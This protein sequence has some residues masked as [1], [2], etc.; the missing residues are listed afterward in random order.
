MDRIRTR[1]KAFTLVELLVVIAIVAILISVLL[2]AIASARDSARTSVASN[3]VRQIVA[4]FTIYANEHEGQYPPI[5]NNIRDPRTDKINMHW[6]DE[7]RIGAYLPQFDDSN[8]DPDNPKNNT[9]GG[10]VFTSPMHPAAGRS[11]TMNF[12]GASAG[13]WWPAGNGRFDFFKPGQDYQH[14]PEQVG[15]GKAFDYNTDFASNVFLIT[16][17][18]GLWPSQSA[19][20]YTGEKRWFTGAQV[21]ADGLPGQRF[22]GGEEPINAAVETLAWKN[23]GA[24]EMAGIEGNELPTYVP[25]YRYPKRDRDP[26]TRTGA[27]MFGMVDGHVEMLRA[28]EVVDDTTGRSSYRVLWSTEDR[29]IENDAY[30]TQP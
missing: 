2:P 22:G 4:A 29:K 9:V 8:L 17:A 7:T 24:P 21:G 26:L 27:A 13:S 5:L 18:W 14:R 11:F 19:D 10:G 12:W 3:N 6:Y 16:D 15:I 30:G 28:S 1:R 20:D 23:E 25:F